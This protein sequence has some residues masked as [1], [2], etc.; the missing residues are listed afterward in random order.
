MDSKIAH[1]LNCSVPKGSSYIYCKY[2]DDVMGEKFDETG[3]TQ[4]CI[5]YKPP[6]LV[7]KIE[8]NP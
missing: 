3:E 1:C 4:A 5:N 8:V 7:K 2:L 6:R